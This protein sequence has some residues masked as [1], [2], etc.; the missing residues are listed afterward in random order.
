MVVRAGVL[1]TS[2]VVRIMKIE[3]HPDS[4]HVD[5]CLMSTSGKDM[6]LCEMLLRPP[7]I[8]KKRGDNR[9][10]LVL[11][12]P[13]AKIAFERAT[14]CFSCRQSHEDAMIRATRLQSQWEK[15]FQEM[16]KRYL[17]TK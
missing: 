14:A 6:K 15:H 17:D 10:S 9:D 16:A 4:M 3:E 11:C 13:A 7:I 12:H 5:G 2:L 8:S 1:D